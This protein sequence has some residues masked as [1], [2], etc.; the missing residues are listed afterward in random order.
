MIRNKK[1][2]HGKLGDGQMPVKWCHSEGGVYADRGNPFPSVH[3]TEK[4]GNGLPRA[5]K[6]SAM[7]I[8]EEMPYPPTFREQRKRERIPAR[9]VSECFFMG[10]A[11]HIRIGYNISADFAGRGGIC[12]AK[13][14]G[15]GA[16]SNRSVVYGGMYVSLCADEAGDGAGVR[17]AHVRDHRTR[18]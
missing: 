1:V 8:K 18:A 2:H 9:K 6:A 4:R 11:F 12:R 5:I 10:I 15:C 7:T 14:V 13:M 16:C 17:R 3:R